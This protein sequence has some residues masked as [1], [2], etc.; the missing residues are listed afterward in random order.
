M[1]N[2][3]TPDP[4]NPDPQ[5]PNS[6]FPDP[7]FPDPQ[8]HPFLTPRGLRLQ[9]LPPL[10]TVQPR[11]LPQYPPARPPSEPP[12]QTPIRPPS[13][14]PRGAPPQ[15]IDR[16]QPIV[17]IR[18]TLKHPDPSALGDR[19]LDDLY[20]VR[21]ITAKQNDPL[22][23]IGKLFIQIDPN[24]PQSL[25]SGSAWVIGPNTI[26][27]AAHNLFDSNTRTWSHALYFYPGFDYY[28]ANDYPTNETGES[29][30]TCQIISGYLPAAYLQ[31]PTTDVDIAICHTDINVGDRLGQT[32]AWQIIDDIDYYQ[33]RP[34][35]ILGYPAT[36][37]FDF[38]K[39]L[40]RSVGDMLFSRQT[41]TTTDPAP[42][43]ATSFGS[44]ASGGPWLVPDGRGGYAAVGV[45]S[46]HA[47]LRYA[48]G[49]HSLA[50]LMSPMINDR[51]IDRLQSTAIHHTF[52][53]T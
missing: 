51:A 37:G 36:S 30:I 31:N 23:A 10:Q 35:A 2:P 39:Q 40:W 47:K 9:Q 4:Q 14:P 7:Q 48:P 19:P 21:R 13:E 28:L 6:Q 11:P 38:G 32:I 46:G 33:S 49:E 44:G 42:V 12:N 8:S 17:N 27:T 53:A 15:A 50:S 52:A 16:S 24:R 26:A 18:P 3:Q 5:T 43:M 29:P 34:I 25:A 41:S 22:R 20:N 1:P 45:T